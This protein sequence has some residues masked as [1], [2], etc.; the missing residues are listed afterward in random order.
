MTKATSAFNLSA[1]VKTC[2]MENL[3]YLPI[4]TIGAGIFSH[5][6]LLICLA[7]DPLKC[8]RNSSTYLVTNLALAD[9][10]ACILGMSRLTYAINVSVVKFI[11][12]TTVLA[13]VFSIFSIAIDRFMVTVRPILHRVILNERRSAIW[14][15]L[16][17]TAS[18]IPLVKNLAFGDEMYDSISYQIITVIVALLT[19]LLY[20]FTYFYVRKQSQGISEQRSQSRNL[21]KQFLKTIIIVALIQIVT[22]VPVN[23]ENA[24]YGKEE[25]EDSAN[26]S[27]R[28]FILF[29]MYCLNFAI[30]PFLYIWRLRHYRKT[31]LLIFCNKLCSKPLDKKCNI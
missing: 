6:L 4:L 20:G 1:L 13:S 26:I 12:Q 7:K 14:V 28:S 8:F 24:I 25:V 17:W 11:G 2:M 5:L 23:V 27:L 31:F 18:S 22:L 3:K 29:E 10:T 21:T 19:S 9:F 15:T 16:I 30:N